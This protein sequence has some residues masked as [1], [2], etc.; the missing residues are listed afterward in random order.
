MVVLETTLE[1]D[2]TSQAEKKIGGK[3]EMTELIIS[4]LRGRH[5]II[6][7]TDSFPDYTRGHD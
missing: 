7:A 3:G 5:K 1:G 6:L 2:V 4:D